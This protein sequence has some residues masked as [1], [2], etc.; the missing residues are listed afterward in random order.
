MIRE[1]RLAVWLSGTALLS[2]LALVA[3]SIIGSRPEPEC[4]D[5]RIRREIAQLVWEADWREIAQLAGEAQSID[6]DDPCPAYR[7]YMGAP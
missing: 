5:C 4:P 6:P 3:V 1:A 2:V 7:D